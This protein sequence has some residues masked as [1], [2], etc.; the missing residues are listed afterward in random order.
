MG[1][2]IEY[3][4]EVSKK[5]EQMKDPRR[6]IA[7]IDVDQLREIVSEI[8]KRSKYTYLSTISAVDLIDNGLIQVNYAFWSI[9]EKALLVLRVHLPREDPRV[10]SIIDIFP[11]AMNGEQEA[12]DLLGVLFVGNPKLRRA[13]LIPKEV[14]EKGIFPLRKDFKG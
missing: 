11:G 6:Y 12:Y 3:L 9:D 2:L 10:P 5:F 13:F 1:Q 8:K 4:K 7:E 14:A